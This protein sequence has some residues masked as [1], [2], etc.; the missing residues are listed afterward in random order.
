MDYVQ[1]GKQMA[2]T[3]VKASM[4]TR[5]EDEAKQLEKKIKPEEKK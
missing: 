3:S 5:V 4:T 2:A 1:K